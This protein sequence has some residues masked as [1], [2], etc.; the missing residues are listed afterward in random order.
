MNIER[1]AAV[2]IPHAAPNN[3]LYTLTGIVIALLNAIYRAQGVDRKAYAASIGCVKVVTY[4]EDDGVRTSKERIYT[5]DEIVQFAQEQMEKDR[6]AAEEREAYER[7]A[8]EEE[9]AEVQRPKG[10]AR[11]SKAA[12]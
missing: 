8:A 7:A 11:K 1:L 12:A 3:V 9:K 4:R 10:R 6:H 5:I 2:V